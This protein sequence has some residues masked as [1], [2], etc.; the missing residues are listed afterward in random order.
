MSWENPPVGYRNEGT[1]SKMT[2]ISG[3]NKS[4]LAVQCFERG[5]V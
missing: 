5:G 2:V 1:D 3:L 4:W